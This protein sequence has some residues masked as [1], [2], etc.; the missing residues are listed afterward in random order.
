MKGPQIIIIVLLAAIASSLLRASDTVKIMPVG[1]SI[2][3]GEHY[4]F[5]AI[6]ERTGYR[7]PLYDMLINSGYHVDFVGS[8]KHGIRPEGDDDWFDWNCEAYP[9]WKIPEI[10]ER[11][12]DALEVYKPDILL[13]HVGTNGADWDKK[14]GQVMEMLDSI[15]KY[16]IE[17]DHPIKVF[18]CKII[19]RFIDEDSVPTSQFNKNVTER[20]AAR[21]GDKI[22]IIMVDMEEGAGLEYSDNLPDPAASPP[23]EGGDMLGRR[24]PGVPYDKYHPN[25]KGNIKMAVKFYEELVKVL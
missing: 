19:K 23:R 21:T 6:E 25:D 15:N 24:Y 14:P 10:A 11:V 3:A 22:E 4:R 12:N 8:Q 16:S 2:T 9:G 18:L 20:V 13:V 5:P 1:N 17:N 7:K